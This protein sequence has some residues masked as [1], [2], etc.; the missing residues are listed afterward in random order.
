MP[1]IKTPV[2]AVVGRSGVGKTTVLQQ[3]L[4]FLCDR[5]YR[6]GVFK[7]SHHSLPESAHGH[8]GRLQPCSWLARATP[9]G[10]ELRGHLCW[11]ELLEWLAEKVDLVLLEG[12]KSSP[13]PKIEVL[14]GQP[15]LLSP[16][17]LI[18]TLGD[19]WPGLPSLNW[20]DPAGWTDFWMNYTK[21]ASRNRGCEAFP[22]FSS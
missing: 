22:K 14:R 15:P 12:G 1:E 6:V 11:T 2:L 13:Y 9:N 8:E 7:H 21:D 18:A 4:Q 20:D 17:H 10:I 19:P 16:E 5:G 3:W